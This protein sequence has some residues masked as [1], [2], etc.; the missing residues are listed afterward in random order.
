MRRQ[1]E[2]LSKDLRGGIVYKSL[3]FKSK[4]LEISRLE[5]LPYTYIRK[6]VHKDESEIYI[7]LRFMRITVCRRGKSH[8]LDNVSNKKMHVI[9]I[10]WR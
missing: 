3:W 10:K 6:H 4:H 8:S 2:L 1:K 7:I 5:M 9:S